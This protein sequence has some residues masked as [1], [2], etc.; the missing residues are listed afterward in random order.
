MKRRCLLSFGLAVVFLGLAQRGTSLACYPQESGVEVVISPKTPKDPS[1]R[2][3]FQEDLTIGVNEGDENYMFGQVV[4]L[5]TD[6]DGN[7]YVTDWDRKRI[8]KYDRQGRY[9]RTIGRKGQ[10]PGEFQN[11]WRPEFDA[12]GHLYVLDIVARSISFFD[13][14]SGQFLRQIKL[15][16]QFHATLMDRQGHFVAEKTIIEESPKGRKY[17]TIY[18]LFDVQ[19][20]IIREF[21]RTVWEPREGPG[22]GEAALIGSLANTLSDQAFKPVPSYFLAPNDDIWIGYPQTYEI[23][24]YGHDGEPKRTIRRDYDPSPVTPKDKARF[25]EEQGSDFFRFLPAPGQALKGKII[26]AVR[27]PDNKPAYVSFALMENGW[28]AVVVD[29][30]QKD[31]AL[32]DL[33]DEKGRY[34]AQ[35]EAA[36]PSE[37]LFFKNGKAYAVQTTE[38]GYKFIKRYRFAN[39]SG[40]KGTS[41][42][43]R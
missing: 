21:L 8:Q 36:I 12:D 17:T 15:P 14:E 23:R 24:I 33:F 5:N 4:Y 19:P 29:S 2:L 25:L 40:P 39:A 9:V 31:V 20:Q 3:V 32:F 26:D 7:F 37:G 42:L 18:G 13:K 10:G 16:A 41:V 34:T 22:S 27:F 43:S 30:P 35:F 6:D 38:E 11:V 28:L 1:M